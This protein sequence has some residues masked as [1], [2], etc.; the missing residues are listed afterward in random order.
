MKG[1]KIMIVL[2][3]IIV[4]LVAVIIGKSMNKTP[5]VDPNSVGMQQEVNNNVDPNELKFRDKFVQVQEDG[6]KLNISEELQK[7][8]I[9]E[10]L[11]ISNIKVV[12]NNNV[13]QVTAN[14]KNPTDKTLGDFPVDIKI[15]DKNG[16]EIATIGGFID[17]V[18]P[19]ESTELN[20]SAT[21]GFANAYDFQI[22]KK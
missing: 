19:G 20:A 11:E 10:G 18:K 5:Q 3:L 13:T 8:K 17:K 7:T 9:V 6:S 4:V 1:K 14:I 21:V 15:F 22:I 12:E 16:K 2:G